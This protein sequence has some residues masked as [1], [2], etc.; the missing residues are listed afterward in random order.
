MPC[1]I[2]LNEKLDTKFTQQ[3]QK[4]ALILDNCTDHLHISNL[5][6]IKLAFLPPNTI[7]ACQPMD[8]GVIH[9]L[10]AHYR[11]DLARACLIAFEDKHEFS[12][13]VK[14]GM[15]L[16]KKSRSAVSIST[17][18]NCFRKVGFVAPCDE[19]KF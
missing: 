9:C 17:I 11:S 5:D 1:C 10:K 15:E 3:K 14:Y 7:A 2:E 16:L 12:V 4:N 8:A 18:R 19:G 6:S 13:D